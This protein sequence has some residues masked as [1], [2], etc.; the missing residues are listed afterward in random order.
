MICTLKS[1]NIVILDYMYVLVF[2]CA[3]QLCVTCENLLCMCCF[4]IS[5][6]IYFPIDFVIL[7]PS[8]AWREDA[9]LL[10]LNL[11][12]FAKLFLVVVLR[13]GKQFINFFQNA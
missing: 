5:Q 12:A 3:S 9:V 1:L 10:N 6:I 11:V 4:I 8:L 13:R 7:R 2:L